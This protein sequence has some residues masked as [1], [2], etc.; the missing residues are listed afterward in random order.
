MSKS[1]ILEIPVTEFNF[2]NFINEISTNFKDCVE[3]E[4]I[5]AYMRESN[6]EKDVY[7]ELN[8]DEI[9]DLKLQDSYEVD[10]LNNN[11]ILYVKF[12][13]DCSEWSDGYICGDGTELA[14]E[15]YED[16][17]YGEFVNDD[18]GFI[19]KS[20]NDNLTIQKGTYGMANPFQQVVRTIDN[21]GEFDEIMI[22]F[23]NKHIKR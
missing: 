2:T 10:L 19:I 5:C 13:L 6:I 1:K 21:A 15:E 18:N 7:V 3:P 20:S 17:D 22:N 14:Y 23:V 11:R 4:F 16:I 8:E 12:V 9:I